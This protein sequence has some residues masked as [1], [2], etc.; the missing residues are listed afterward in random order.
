MRWFTELGYRF[1][2][3]GTWKSVA[4]LSERSPEIDAASVHVVFVVEKVAVPVIRSSL[5]PSLKL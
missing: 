1:A 4:G 3:L 2:Q 5:S